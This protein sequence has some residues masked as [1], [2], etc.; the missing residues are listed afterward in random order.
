MATREDY[1]MLSAVA[2]NAERD[3]K[4][5]LDYTPTGWSQIDQSTNPVNGFG[6][7]AYSNANGTE[8]VIAY[9]GTNAYDSYSDANGDVM[10]D[11]VWSTASDW[12][13]G[14]LP[15]TLGNVLGGRIEVLSTLFGQQIF[16]A[17]LF[18]AQVKAANHNATIT[19][20]GH[21]LG[22]GLASVMSVWFDQT[23]TTFAEMPLANTANSTSAIAA[24]AT[25]LL[26]NG[27]VDNKLLALLPAA[28]LGP[29]LDKFGVQGGTI[30]SDVYANRVNNVTHYYV[31]GEIASIPRQGAPAIIGAGKDNPLINVHHNVSAETLHSMVLHASFLIQPALRLATYA[32]PD[33]LAE[34]F[35]KSLYA[36]QLEGA[37]KDFLNGL[38]ND[39]IKV[40]YT[41]TNGLLARFAAD[42]DKLTQYG[43]NLKT[44][45]LSKAVIDVA[46]A[47]YYFMQN[48]FSGKDFYNAIT[49]GI[50]FDLSDINSPNGWASNKTVT[51][52]DN[53]IITQYLND[54]QT[55]RSY[56]SQDN[57]WSIQSG[58]DAL[59]ATGTDSN[60]DAMIG[61]TTDD[62]LDGGAGNDFLFGGDGTDTLTGGEGNDLLIGGVGDDT[63][64]GGAGVDN[65]IIEGRD[66]I[67]DSDGLG[68]IKDKAGNI[69][70]GAIEK[71]ADGSY[72]FLSDLNISVTK[73][74]NLTLTL[75]DGSVAV[76]E[77]FK[78]G[79]LGLEVVN[80]PTIETTY[81]AEGD[82]QIHSA[83][84]APGGAGSDWQIIKTYNEQYGTDENGN[85]IL[86]SYSVDYYLIDDKGNPTEPGG[87]KR[88]DV[89]HDT[90]AND[91]LIGG[92]G[93]D[94][95][96]DKKGGDDILEGGSGRDLIQGGGGKDILIG[97]EDGDI[98]SGGSGDDRL[99]GT[100]KITTEQAIAQGNVQ[101][102]TGKQGDWLSGG[103]GDD[104]LVG[105]AGNDV[106]TG[107]GGKDLLIGGAG[108]DDILGDSDWLAQ[109]F[110]WT[111]TDTPQYRRFD[112]V[113]GLVRAADSAA[114]VIYAGAGAD[115]V[116]G[117]M[118][119]DVIYGENGNDILSGNSGSDIVFGGEGDDK[120]NGG[121]PE[122]FG[123]T[124]LD[125]GDDY[126]DGGAGNDQLYGE[127]GSDTVL[128]GEAANDA[129]DAKARIAA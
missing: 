99:Y 71:R 66:T 67:Q 68:L 103:A 16:Q 127:G 88:D 56:L 15:L 79:D 23:A 53:A 124:T 6:A 76:I 39:Q 45:A 80:A 24:A 22:G 108:D 17:A 61:G 75:T 32:L 10:W 86:I 46:I 52:L 40:G 129:N 98:L 5:Q 59:N 57:Y 7:Q 47:D 83:E 73:D 42:I 43:E 112:P 96:G 85:Q 41:D 78:N 25:V 111:V 118:G 4:N 104:T 37:Q 113:E 38:L 89:L 36:K 123:D 33:L 51:Q 58:A 2:Y 44:G 35:D 116:W 13:F 77:N 126:L 102:G 14:N 82:P 87:P 70:T 19:F 100:S 3:P 84:I 114:D 125:V 95:L 90:A 121:G 18:Y 128:G 107:G 28:V 29:L 48:G 34:I 110:E 9:E 74:G 60:N 91:H 105:S 21:S 92:A 49:G 20:T 12:L 69:I 101:T 62:T 106:L 93:D 26:A 122:F 94:R 63:L 27:Y 65:Y 117:G 109:K 97:G 55:A 30:G 119:D 31:D 1:A 81:T 120:I 8:I 115:H 54:D 50:N 11:R 64:N 72:V